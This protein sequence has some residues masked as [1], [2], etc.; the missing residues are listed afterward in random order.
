MITFLG[1]KC[2]V[3][4]L[5]SIT[6]ENQ[7]SVDKRPWDTYVISR[8][9]CVLLLKFEKSDPFFLKIELLF[10]LSTQYNVENQKELQEVFLNIV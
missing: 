2:I 10:P 9:V 8:I 4:V 1:P 3:I 7:T 6:R 5:F